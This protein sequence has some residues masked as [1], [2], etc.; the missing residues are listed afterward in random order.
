MCG[1]YGWI[2]PKASMTTDLNLAKLTID[3]LLKTQDRGEDATGFYSPS[4][5]IVKDAVPAEEFVDDKVPASIANERFFIGHCRQASTKYDKTNKNS[6]L[7]AQPFESNN[8]VLVHNGTITTPRIKGYKYTSAVDS[9]SII[10]FADKTGVRNALANVD[11]DS[12][13]VLSLL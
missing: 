3:G 2:K 10:A 9:E 1:I 6:P 4:L 12:T 7:N 8:F 13:V 11:G 5:G